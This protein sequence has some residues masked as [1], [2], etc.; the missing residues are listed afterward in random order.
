MKATLIF[1][2]ALIATAVLLIGLE[3]LDYSAEDGFFQIEPI[4]G[5]LHV[6]ALPACL[7]MPNC[8][9]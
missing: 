8:Q 7:L 2:L 6:H 5:R 3:R 4:V 9:R 1:D